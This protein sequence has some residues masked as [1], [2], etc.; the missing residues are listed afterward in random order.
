MFKP[1]VRC[2]DAVKVNQ[3]ANIYARRLDDTLHF[4]LLKQKNT[5]Q[6][7]STHISSPLKK[8]KHSC[9]VHNGGCSL[10]DT[11]LSTQCIF[12]IYHHISGLIVVL[13]IKSMACTGSALHS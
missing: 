11:A 7:K 6:D 2:A 8:K 9:F 10:E 12:S 1:K 3:C 13:S 5:T 4:R